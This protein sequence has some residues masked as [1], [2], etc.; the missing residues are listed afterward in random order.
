MNPTP[1]SPHLALPAPEGLGV[2]VERAEGCYI[3]DKSGKRYLD[4]CSGIAVS[5]IG[6]CHPAV[7]KAVQQQVEQ[8][9]QII[10]Y[11][12]F[13][14]WPQN[15]L[16]HKVTSLLPDSIDQVYFVNSG[17]EAN[18]AALKLAKRTTGRSRLV[19]FHGSYHGSTQGSLSVT[20]NEQKKSSFRPLLPGV[21]FLDFDEAAGLDGITKEH[22]AVIIEPIQGDA[23]VRMPSKEFM[24]A[25]RARSPP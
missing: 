20:G 2:E 3:W 13:G 9:M 23:G 11:G 18:E 17:T 5:N 22:A 12:E 19:A 4:F 8:F 16:A 7:V 21:D 14:Y 24:L 10:P 6:H 1:F 15:R 25:L